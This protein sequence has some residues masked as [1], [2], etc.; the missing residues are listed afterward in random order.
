[1]HTGWSLLLCIPSWIFLGRGETM[2]RLS[3]MFLANFGS[4][5]LQLFI[6]QLD[7]ASQFIRFGRHGAISFARGES[8]CGHG[9]WLWRLQDCLLWFKEKHSQ[10]SLHFHPSPV[11]VLHWWRM[12]WGRQTIRMLFGT[13]FSSGPHASAPGCKGSGNWNSLQPSYLSIVYIAW[14]YRG[15]WHQ[16][17]DW[18]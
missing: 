6:V 7:K 13:C 8:L 5:W 4:F 11:I 12:N 15:R 18:C 1:M 16:Q 9:I 14:T 17:W 10:D 3:C 2:S